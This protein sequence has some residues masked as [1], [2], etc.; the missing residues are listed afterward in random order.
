MN[1]GKPDTGR[2]ATGRWPGEAESHYR[3]IANELLSHRHLSVPSLLVAYSGGLDSHF[4]LVAAGRWG[5]EY[6][7]PVRAVYIDH[8]LQEGSRHWA[9]H[10]RS[11][12][13]SLAIPFCC[14][15]VEV[16]TDGESPEQAARD[17]RYRALEQQLQPGEWLLAAHHANDQA[18]TLLLQLLRGAG[19]RGLAA[20]P[21]CRPFGSGWLL[22]PMRSLSRDALHRAATAMQWQW[23][24]DPSNADVQFDRNYLRHR[25]LPVLRQRWPAVDRAISRSASHAAHAARLLEEL[26]ALDV[27]VSDDRIDVDLLRALSIDRRLNALRGWIAQHG[28]QAPSTAV[29]DHLVGDLVMASDDSGGCFAFAGAEV[30]RHRQ[31]LYIGVAA[32]FQSTPPFSHVWANRAEALYIPETNQTLRADDLPLS[33]IPANEPLLIKS[34]QGGEKIKLENH[35]TRQSVKSLLQQQGQPPWLRCRLPFV[36]RNEELVGVVGVGFVAAPTAE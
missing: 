21:A 30:R 4:L 36:W 1:S 6:S 3:V 16:A 20:M 25:I 22:R 2:P 17:A 12:C 26:A 35:A 31:S 11:V 28:Y 18:E 24:E 23:V 15:A 9:A 33:W 32:D 7:V 34:R 10:C 14:V 19:V 27:P 8:D 13:E 5:E 29:L